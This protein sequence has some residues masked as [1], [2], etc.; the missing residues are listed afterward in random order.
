MNPQ[1]T[2]LDTEC[3]SLSHQFLDHHKNGKDNISTP[4]PSQLEDWKW[5]ST[6]QLEKVNFSFFPQ[7]AT[8]RT[9]IGKEI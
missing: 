6:V 2:H 5:F 8:E 7:L 4:Q 1:K 3:Q 9:S